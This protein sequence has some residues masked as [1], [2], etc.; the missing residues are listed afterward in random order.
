MGNQERELKSQA[1]MEGLLKAI[2]G[3]EM[4][5]KVL[6]EVNLD[7]PNE[8]NEK[9]VE[10][11]D[12]IREFDPISIVISNGNA[13]ANISVDFIEGEG[14][15][16]GITLEMIKSRDESLLTSSDNAVAN[17]SDHVLT[18]LRELFGNLN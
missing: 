5:K 11:T 6:A 9:L 16:I 12:E 7:I 10:S 8:S 3:E 1:K 18:S 14:E 2:F 17:I 4:G 15:S 13:T